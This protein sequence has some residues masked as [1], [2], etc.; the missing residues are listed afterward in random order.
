MLKLSQQRNRGNAL[1]YVSIV[2]VVIM[3]FVSFAVDV[4]RVQVAKTELRTAADSAAMA[5]IAGLKISVGQAQTGAMAAAS[6]NS[7]DGSPIILD[8]STDIEFGLWNSPSRTFTALSDSDRASANAI[9]ITTR[10]TAERGTAVPLVFGQIIGRQTCDVW[11]TAIATSRPTGY[12]V[13]G[14]DYITMGGNATDS[15]WS[16]GGDLSTSNLGAIG[17]NGDITLTGSSE[18]HGD[19][20]PGINK[21]VYGASHVN[22][23]TNSVVTP[24]KFPNGSAGGYATSN[25][26]NQIPAEALNG[27]SF[28]PAANHEYTLPGGKYYFN[29]FYLGSNNTLAFTGPATIYVYGAFTL[30]GGANTSENLPGNLNLVMVP[31]PYNGT[32]PGTVT[33]G[34]GTELF[35]NIYAPQSPIVISGNG[36]IY[37]SVLGKSVDMTGNA[38]IHYDLSL[39]GN[40]NGYRLVR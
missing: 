24:F 34:S 11:A 13:I 23:S 25:D 22:G 1:I 18:V 8:P 20:N 5:A 39:E 30:W 3:G 33:L 28:Q 36:D 21:T 4:A 2:L 26:N 6:D 27:N 31:N 19:A 7:A 14:L 17:S 37:G 38:A 32:P 15:Y 10:R 35:A 16:R 12:G 40:Y 9:R 29:N